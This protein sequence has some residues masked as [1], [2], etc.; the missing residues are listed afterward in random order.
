[1]KIKFDRNSWYIKLLSTPESWCGLVWG[2]LWRVVG[3][4]AGSIFLYWFMYALVVGNYHVF[5]G[6]DETSG[7]I[8]AGIIIDFLI[9]YIAGGIAVVKRE[10]IGKWVSERCPKLEYEDE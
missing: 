8:P 9:L 3:V 10:K 6:E 1:M 7:W 2:L 4:V 5:F